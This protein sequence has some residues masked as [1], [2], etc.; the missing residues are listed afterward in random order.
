MQVQ[1]LIAEDKPHCIVIDGV[2]Y[3][4]KEFV[5]DAQ[6][7]NW[8]T[9]GRTEAQLADQA[10]AEFPPA[11][12]LQDHVISEMAG[13]YCSK[14]V[15]DSL[16]DTHRKLNK[17]YVLCDKDY[18]LFAGAIPGRALWTLLDGLD[19][20]AVPSSETVAAAELLRDKVAPDRAQFIRI[21]EVFTRHTSMASDSECARAGLPRW[22]GT[23]RV[24]PLAV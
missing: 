5:A 16:I 7:Y 23:E 21:A 17:R 9:G 4:L 14:S 18:G 20:P 6:R 19:A 1:I 13:F 3:D 10:N 22:G 12:T 8:L 15:V 11:P 2:T 24:V